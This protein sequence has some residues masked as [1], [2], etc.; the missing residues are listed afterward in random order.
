L[1]WAR[2]STTAIQ[3]SHHLTKLSSDEFEQL[4]YQLARRC[5]EFSSVQWYRSA[6]IYDGDEGRDIVAHRHTDA[7]L[8]RWYIQCKQ[9]TRVN[10][11][12]LHSELDTLARHSAESP[13]FTPHVIVFASASDIAPRTR[14]KAAIYARALGLPAPLYWDR[15]EL[16][17]ML[18][19][20]PE[21]EEEFFERQ[22]Q[23]LKLRAQIKNPINWVIAT[24]LCAAL[25][26]AAR[27]VLNVPLPHHEAAAPSVSTPIQEPT[28]MP[29]AVMP[30]TPTATSTPLPTTAPTPAPTAAS[31]P[32][33]TT[34]STPAPTAT[35]TPT[36]TP[37]IVEPT[38]LDPMPG[39]RTRASVLRWEGELGTGQSFVVHLQ[40]LENNQI[41]TSPALTTNCWEALL[42]V[43]WYGGWR[44]QVRVMQGDAILAQSEAWVFWLDPFPGETLPYPPSCSE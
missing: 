35:P 39:A 1:T 36:P 43:E 26:L 32:L 3:R 7:E 5:G 6:R 29:V 16:D 12:T 24:V 21:T 34:T 19:A 38:L 42:P 14:R 28:P 37:F 25:L 27:L 40:H 31:T 20:Q 13:G 17:D 15:R 8:E 44:W 33:P 41:R 23:L 4:V 10:Y 2:F 30:P 11:A 18:K 9:H 22:G